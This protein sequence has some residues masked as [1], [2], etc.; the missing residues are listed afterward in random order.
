MP[1]F[2]KHASNFS[3]NQPVMSN[4]EGDVHVAH[5]WI[6]DQVPAIRNWLNPPD[7][8]VNFNAAL[9]TR[10]PGTGQGLLS[11]PE[12]LKWKNGG[13]THMLWIQGKV[14]SGK[15][16]LST[17][18][19]D[20]LNQT[21]KPGLVYFYYFDNRDNSGSKS[22]YRGFL[23]SILFQ[24]AISQ[25]NLVH[26]ALHKLYTT[27]KKGSMQAS[28]TQLENTFALVAKTAIQL[29]YI[30]LDAVD[31]CTHASQVMQLLDSYQESFC[32]AVTSRYP[33]NSQ[34]CLN[35]QLDEIEADLSIF[36]N[37]RLGKQNWTPSLHKEVQ[38]ALLKGAQGQFRW[39]DC[40]LTILEKCIGA[41]A[42]RK[43]LSK[44][45]RDL[46]ETYMQALERIANGE[47]KDDAYHL[48]LWLTYAFEPLSIKQVEDIVTVDLEKQS[49]DPLDR[50]G[51]LTHML[52]NIIDSALVIIG[53]DNIV[54]LAHN[55]VK[56][57]L[58]SSHNL[59]LSSGLLE[60]NEKLAN[61]VIAET[62]II[63][64]AHIPVDSVFHWI[65]FPLIFYSARYWHA[66]LR[67]IHF[68]SM[69]QR[70]KDQV[71]DKLLDDKKPYIESWITFCK[72]EMHWSKAKLATQLYYAAA[73]G[74]THD[75]HQL[76]QSGYDVHAQG[77]RYGN[78]LQAAVV[79]GYEPVVHVLLEHGA[80]VNAPGGEYGTALCA[81]AFWGHCNVIGVLLDHGA[82][83]N[84]QCG[85]YANALYAAALKGHQGV[86]HYLLD[87]GA[88][89][90]ARGGECETPLCAAA[91]K[92]YRD[93]V[94]DLLEHGADANLQCGHY[95]S[96]LYAAASEGHQGVV[97]ELLEHGADANARGGEYEIPLCAAAVLGHGEIVHDLL[98]HEADANAQGSERFITPLYL[99]ATEGYE[100][101]VLDLLAHGAHVNT[102]CREY[103]TA[104][105]A[106]TLW[107]HGGVILA[108]LE[109]GADGDG[110][111]SAEHGNRFSREAAERLKNEINGEQ[112]LDTDLSSSAVKHLSKEIIGLEIGNP[113]KHLVNNSSGSSESPSSI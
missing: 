67:N 2:F 82:D 9:E 22:N 72:P 112:E 29:D 15:T 101:A 70:T 77:G 36:L 24:M 59:G 95:A 88:H 17:T 51:D 68:K 92:G 80:E 75:V 11:N 1:S 81:A 83:I 18:I 42:I 47:Q 61:E 87:R 91:F 30:V 99:A 100:D 46:E 71:I 76:L 96:A 8:S 109:Y 3:L 104:L 5:H 55:S 56:E 6:S 98:E 32:V 78:A 66:H 16:V 54:Q 26:P 57:C 33:A 35:I 90:D 69:N 28:L 65:Q 111:Q 50:P 21:P 19:I 4:I 23:L 43:V 94:H 20:D 93:I 84:A 102:Q 34:S 86:V 79:G 63:Y 10:T 7:S 113:Y 97:H 89:I 74:L 62:C 12:Y 13:E 73:A 85:H 52:Y 60:F 44:L 53:P 41:K 64:L 108:L 110:T 103:G 31:E 40:Q 48:L 27:C 39:V 38:K 107:G 37:T 106:A 49:F 58:I 45:P 105:D 25:D 14:G